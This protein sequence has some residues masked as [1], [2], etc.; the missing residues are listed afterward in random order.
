[1][2]VTAQ[3]PAWVCWQQCCCFATHTSHQ[4]QTLHA[5]AKGQVNCNTSS[6]PKTWTFSITC[7]LPRTAAPLFEVCHKCTYLPYRLE[8]R[9]TSVTTTRTFA[10]SSTATSIRNHSLA[11][12]PQRCCWISAPQGSASGQQRK[13]PCWQHRY[14]CI[15][16]APKGKKQGTARRLLRRPNLCPR[17]LTL[18]L[19]QVGLC[20]LEAHYSTLL[21][22]Q[23]T[24]QPVV[25]CCLAC[26]AWHASSTQPADSASVQ[27]TNS[28]S[29]Q[30]S[31]AC[32]L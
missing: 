27:P 32:Q 7:L 26:L 6:H 3:A 28:N 10:V 16:R 23:H 18:K 14:S 31:S 30:L 5:A 20:W 17:N 24:A 12:Q 8:S 21:C 9:S 13:F 11:G 4:H 25:L 1:V 29:A 19:L 2:A 22:L 15:H